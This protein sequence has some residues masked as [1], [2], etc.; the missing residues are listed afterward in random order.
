MQIDESAAGQTSHL[1]IGESLVLTLKENPSTGYRWRVDQGCDKVLET[2][3]DEFT[4]GEARP[5][6]PGSHSWTF[7]ARGSGSC[8]L[9]VESV[10]PWETASTGKRLRFPVVV[11]P[12]S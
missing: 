6:A 10:R 5:G 9:T 12:A 3:H 8:D 1:G 7:L 11:S 2:T 4:P